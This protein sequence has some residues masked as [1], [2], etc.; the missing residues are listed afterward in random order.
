MHDLLLGVDVGTSAAKAALFNGTGQLLAVAQ[1][2]YGLSHLRPGWVE[3]N[4]E[5]WWQAVCTAIRSVLDEVSQSRDR[6]LG[7]AVSGQGPSLIALDSNG[8]ALR[9]ALIWMDRRAEREAQRMDVS[10]DVYGITGNRA[11][12]YYVAPKLLWMKDHEP[13]LLAK[14]RFFTQVTGYINY[15]LTGVHSLDPAHATLLQLRDYRKGDWA[16][17][18]CD[19]CGVEPQQF[20]AITPAHERIGAVAEHAAEATGLRPGIPVVTGTVDALAAG[21]EAGAVEPGNVAE[22]TGTSTVLIMPTHGNIREKAFISVPHAVPGINLLLGAMVASGASLQWFL[23]QFGQLEKEAERKSGLNPFDLL[24]EQAG[25]VASSGGVIFMPYMM[26][27]RSPIWHTQA[28]GVLF[29]LTLATPRGAVIRSILEGTTF[30]LRHNID[31]A[32]EAGIRIEELRSVGGGTRSALWNQIKADVLGVPVVLPSTSVGAP[33]GDAVLAGLG[34]GLYGDPI[35]ALR[36]LIRI[37]A[38]YDPDPTMKPRYDA[39][40]SLFRDLYQHLRPDFDRAGEIQI[41]W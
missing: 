4:P 28:R 19:L 29:G 9:P 12:A 17:A 25:Q 10:L 26:G 3:Q 33:F 16:A 35:R 22:M 2:Q 37:K 36:D 38:R 27:E 30:A 31:V 32:L 6:L 7:M 15:R 5:D 18:I 8:K 40:Y 23:D 20:P 21:F 13:H 14:T 24:T 39:A 34:S 41:A 1:S 11:D